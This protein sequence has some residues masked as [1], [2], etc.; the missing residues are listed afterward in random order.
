MQQAQEALDEHQRQ[1]QTEAEKKAIQE[2]INAIQGKI[3]SLEAE[4]KAWQDLVDE[5]QRQL[6]RAEIELKN[7][8]TIEETI[9]QGKAQTMENYKNAYVT[10][11]NEMIAAER[12]LQQVQKEKDFLEENGAFEIPMVGELIPEHELISREDI[13]AMRP[14]ESVEAN[15][16]TRNPSSSGG[17]KITNSVTKKTTSSSTKKST[18]KKKAVGSTGL[19]SSGAYNID[20]L[21]AEALIPPAGRIVNLPIGTGVIP[22]DMTQN[23][24]NIGKY[25]MSQLASLFGNDGNKVATSNNVDNSRRVIIQNL[26]V[27][28]NSASD[29]V[30]QLQNLAITTK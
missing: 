7:N 30:R 9:F 2:Q 13:G 11:I 23:L 24:M 14:A 17:K 1:K 22:A 21:G 29:F 15:F 4:K 10:A 3:E 26:E 18:T 5:Q 20:E 6:Q 25:S 8:A 27:R 28:T 19:T 12:A 16:G